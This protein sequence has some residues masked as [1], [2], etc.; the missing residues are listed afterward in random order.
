[1]AMKLLL[2][3][4]VALLLQSGQLPVE[5]DP[6][7]PFEPGVIADRKLVLRPGQQAVVAI[8]PKGPVLADPAAFR[9]EGHK[10]VGNVMRF[11]FTN[12]VE[13]GGTLLKIENGYERTVDV[14]ARIFSASGHSETTS[15]CLVWP[16]IT[17]MEMW[18]HPIARIEISKFKQTDSHKR[19]EMNCS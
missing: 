15:M 2:T 8:G 9:I 3:L 4:S 7:G 5:I 1:M 14:D 11:T 18:P 12:D 13:R 19:G 6:P 17:G 10:S 16:H